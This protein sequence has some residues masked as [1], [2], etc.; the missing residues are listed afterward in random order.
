MYMYLFRIYI[1]IHITPSYPPPLTTI[2]I[3]KKGITFSFRLQMKNAISEVSNDLRIYLCPYS[4]TLVVYLTQEKD[5]C[6][7]LFTLINHFTFSIFETFLTLKQQ[8]L[9]EM[10][11]GKIQWVFPHNL[12]NDFSILPFHS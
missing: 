3:F 6:L 12:G 9:L 10:A 4:S 5:C 11:L 7:F 2:L 8:H 1:Y